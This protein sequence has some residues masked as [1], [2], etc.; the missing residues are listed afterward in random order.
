M[1]ALRSRMSSEVRISARATRSNSPPTCAN[2]T[3]KGLN[4]ETTDRKLRGYR[5]MVCRMIAGYQQ[6]RCSRFAEARLRV[7]QAGTQ[8]LSIL[9]PLAVTRCT[10]RPM[11]VRVSLGLVPALGRVDYESTLGRVDYESIGHERRNARL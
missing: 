5:Y 4:A 2:K 8:D 1:A 3:P 6:Q 7:F 10:A 9:G 11:T